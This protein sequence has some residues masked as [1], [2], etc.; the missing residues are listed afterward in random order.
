MLTTLAA[1]KPGF[2]NSVMQA[3]A[4][5]RAV[6][7][8]F[9]YPGRVMEAGADLAPPPPLHQATAAIGLTLFDMDTPVWLD[10]AAATPEVEAFFRFHC[11]CPVS[12]SPERARFAIIADASGLRALDHFDCGTDEAPDRSTT[13]IIQVARF[14][15]GSGGVV[16]TGPGIKD[17]QSILVDGVPVE[18]WRQRQAQRNLFPRGIDIIF[19]V[20]HRLV[21]LPRTTGV[22]V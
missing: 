14:L 9:A 22:D 5:F 7:H 12:P 18:F 21:G 3:Q 13:V 17:T 10:E 6:L 11:G 2:E 15:Q 16:L 20:D 4:T 19:T 8:A 1:L